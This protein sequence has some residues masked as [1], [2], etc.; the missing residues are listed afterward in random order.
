MG[1]TTGLVA[2]G[3]YSTPGNTNTLFD[4]LLALIPDPDTP[5]SNGA[6]AQQGGAGGGNLDEMSPA[7]AAQLRVEL[8]AAR[9]AAGNATIV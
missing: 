4:R 2:Q 9:T 3:D 6:G 5:L 8:T 1:A 7:A